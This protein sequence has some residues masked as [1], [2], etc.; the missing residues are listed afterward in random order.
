MLRRRVFPIALMLIAYVSL[1]TA[2]VHAIV[3]RHDQL[4]ARYLELAKGF[5]AYGDVVEAGSTLI[6][7][8]WLLTAGHVAKV[9]TPYTSYASVNG[10]LYTIDRVVMHPDYVAAGLR[11]RTDLALLR[12]TTSVEGVE[13]VRL[14]KTPDEAGQVVTFFGRGQTGNGLTG[15]TGGDGKMRGATNKVE[16]VDP[17]SVIFLFD[18]PETATELEGISG[19]GDSGGPA[20]LKVRGEW[21]IVGVS[22]QNKGAGQGPCRYGTT[23]FYARVSTA[24]GWIEETIR[25]APESTVAWKISSPFRA[26]P[27]SRP[28]EV[29]SALIEAFN[30]GDAVL[31]EAF[32]QKFRDP[33]SLKRGTPQSRATSYAELVAK[34]GKLTVLEY[35][36]DPNGRLQILLR[37][38]HGVLYELSLYF[39]DPENTRFDGY[40]LGIVTPPHVGTI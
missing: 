33:Q 20:L 19:P 39:L 3:I 21:T 24:V 36:E 10:K 22:S 23:E 32:N 31:N 11:G 17:T 40:W 26:W 37:N 8:R 15:P 1:S 4:D 29:G 5:T 25:S 38:Q 14:H 34:V 7:P 9:I 35:A 13:P 6:A 16:S 28:G 27:K 12:L 2:S 18:Q 30:S